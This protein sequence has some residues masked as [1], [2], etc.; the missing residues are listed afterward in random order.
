MLAYARYGPQRM[1]D[2][3]LAANFER[4]GLTCTPIGPSDT[5]WN[6]HGTQAVF[7]SCDAFAI[8]AFRGTEGD[9]PD[10]SLYDLDFVLVPEH[11]FR[12]TQQSAKPLL[13]HLAS[14][15]QLFA[16]PCLVH[17]GFQRALKPVWEKVHGLVTGYRAAHPSA[18]VRFTGH[19]LGGALAVLAFSRFADPDFSLCTFGCPRVGD[20]ALG[21]RVDV[22]KAE[23]FVNFNDAVAHVPLESLLYRH[24]PRQ[25]LRFDEKGNLNPA[26]DVLPQDVD[27]LIAALASLPASLH[28][29]N[30]GTIEA[31]PSVVDHSPARYCFRLWDCV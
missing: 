28:A 6:A 18:E 12:P 3:E 20:A 26:G 10:D 25:C 11:D 9:D 24:A 13:G 8:L 30:L 21:A 17:Q 4:A 14:V 29:G 27:S 2:A 5:D 15:A 23:R 7:A 16:A 19:S 22:N 31:P 1:T